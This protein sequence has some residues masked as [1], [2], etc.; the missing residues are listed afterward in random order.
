MCPFC[1]I[2]DVRDACLGLGT[3]VIN[4]FFIQA[5]EHGLWDLKM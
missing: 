5:S 2:P 1:G 4:S 3:Y